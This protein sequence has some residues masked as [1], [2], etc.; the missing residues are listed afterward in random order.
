M[1]NFGI[2]CA[3][4]GR[5]ELHVDFRK[6]ARTGDPLYWCEGPP[7]QTVCGPT[8]ALTLARKQGLVPAAS[9]SET[10]PDVES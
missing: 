5:N 6:D 8:C 10:P 2:K 1:F 9:S 3:V 4:C 7:R